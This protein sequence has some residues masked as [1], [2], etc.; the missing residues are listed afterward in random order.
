M[1][2][3]RTALTSIALGVCVAA[4]NP[5][6]AKEPM[7]VQKCGIGTPSATLWMT[8]N[9]WRYTDTVQAEAAYQRL[10]NGQ[11]PWP[12]WFHPEV[13]V[14][15]PGTRFQMALSSGQ[16]KTSPGGFG[17]FDYIDSVEQVRQYLAVLPG[18]KKDIDRMVTYEVRAP[19]LVSV[20][21]IGP[22]VDQDSCKL[23]TGE[24]TQIQFLVPP[25]NRMDYLSVV[26]ERPIQ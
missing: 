20:G 5:S 11:S 18:W 10:V 15:M 12:D 4:A 2:R 1:T 23:Y 6:A 9:A 26:G 3:Y 14:L 25:A 17:T 13:S 8:R 16:A 24:F 19:M 21:P 22:Q 7:V